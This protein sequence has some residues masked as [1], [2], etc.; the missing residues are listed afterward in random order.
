MQKG[1]INGNPES[2]TKCQ[3]ILQKSSEKP[4]YEV[5][6]VINKQPLFV[7]EHLHRLQQSCKNKN[8]APP[9]QKIITKSITRA[10]NENNIIQG[11]IRIDYFYAEEKKCL[12]VYPIPFHYPTLEQYKYGVSTTVLYLER[13][14]PT[15]KIWR[16]DLR[17]VENTI[18]EEQKVYEVILVNNQG[19]ITEG[20]RS[21][22][23]FTDSQSNLVTPPADMAL[24]GIT[25]EK[26]IQLCKKFG[27]KFYEQKISINAIGKYEGSFL[28]GTSPKVLPIKNI[29]THQYDVNNRVIRILMSA[30][31]EMIRNET[32]TDATNPGIEI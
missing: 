18:I 11:N 13:P 1:I 8:I 19:F 2:L 29:D 32:G 28:T 6:R 16:A 7:N 14:N 3:E 25:R 17:A 23:F 12:Q 22:I 9:N 10:I 26:I 20:S 15:S 4:V 24:P 21:N 27:I 31:D 30:F 5:L